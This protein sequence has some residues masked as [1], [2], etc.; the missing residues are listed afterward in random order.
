MKK[1][2]ALT[3]CLVL[4]LTFFAGC[5]SSENNTDSDDEI[6]IVTT[7]FPI[8]DWT[9]NMIGDDS[10]NYSVSMLIDNGVD[11]HS[12][13][14]TTADMV[15]L[16]TCDVFI[17]V[18]GESDAWVEDLLATSTNTDMIAISLFDILGDSVVFEEL[19]EGM[20]ETEHSHSDDEEETEEDHDHD[21]DEESEEDHDHDEEEEDHDHE[22]EEIDEHV[23]LSVQNAQV[24][25]A[26]IADTL[27]SI[28]P[29]NSS[30][31]NSNLASYVSELKVLDSA[32]AEMVASS[33]RDTVLFADRFPFRYLVDDYG[34]TYYAAFAGCSAE[35]EASFETIAFLAGKVDK[36]DLDV[37]LTVT[38]V[39]HK[40]AETVVSVT[41]TQDQTILEVSSMETVS[42]ADLE[43]GVSYISIMEDNLEIFREALN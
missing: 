34:L 11:M 42:S 13:Q 4:C 18:G 21:H 22:E 30:T 28:D 35:T 3:L 23:W 29:N 40:I 15:E 8:Y 43:A 5:G 25:C 39:T 31:Y 10:E 19:V 37:V 7:I 36:L 17:Y 12:F 33:S 14:P 6:I 32:Y 16:Y 26:A 1:F 27:S 20:E 24:I 9:M 41:A 2:I 38:G